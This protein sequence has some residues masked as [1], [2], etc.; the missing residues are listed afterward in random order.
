M[1][2]AIQARRRFLVAFAFG[3]ELQDLDFAGGELSVRQA[4]G[5]ARADGG[6][7]AAFTGV[8]GT[9]GLNQIL[10]RGGFE[11]GRSV[12][13][14]EMNGKYLLRHHGWKA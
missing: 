12:H 8:D 14:L 10:A 11:H 6:R 3:D 2:S 1:T 9:D 4:F 7:D 13:Q 5:Q